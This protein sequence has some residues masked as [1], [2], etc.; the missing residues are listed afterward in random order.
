MLNAQRYRTDRFYPVKKSYKSTFSRA[1]PSAEASRSVL[2]C[3]N[4]RYHVRVRPTGC[5]WLDLHVPQVVKS[6][7]HKM[8]RVSPSDLA[9]QPA[10]TSWKMAQQLSWRVFRRNP[11]RNGHKPRDLYLESSESRQ[12]AFRYRF[13]G[14]ETSKRRRLVITPAEAIRTEDRRQLRNV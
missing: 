5:W 11:R 13:L 6:V 8:L 7:R 12:L 9:A 4:D 14:K 2:Y 10:Q 3:F 1:E